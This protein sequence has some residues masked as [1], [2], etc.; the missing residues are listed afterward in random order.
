MEPASDVSLKFERLL[1]NLLKNSSAEAGEQH[2]R[3]SLATDGGVSS[4]DGHISA[5]DT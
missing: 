3:A 4:T 1:G 5:D 2:G